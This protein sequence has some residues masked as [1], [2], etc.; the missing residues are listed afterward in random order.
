[1]MAKNAMRFYPKLHRLLKRLGL[2][3]IL[4]FLASYLMDRS[5]YAVILVCV[6]A[7]M[8]CDSFSIWSELILVMLENRK[9]P[10]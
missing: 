4:K 7:F 3:S 8:T 2:N 6:I 9:Y 10:F 1:M 5:Q